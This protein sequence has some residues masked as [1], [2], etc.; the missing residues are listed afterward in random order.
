M[1]QA[2]PDAGPLARIFQDVRL[3]LRAC[4][5]VPPS[6]LT[7]LLVTP[8]LQQINQQER[9]RTAFADYVLR[10]MTETGARPITPPNPRLPARLVRVS[11]NGVKR[12]CHSLFPPTHP[13]PLA[14]LL[15]VLSF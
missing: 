12:T 10:A 2:F 8:P 11:S 15:I 5:A 14:A 13:F 1:I 6:F 7:C 3:Q 9:A 4:C